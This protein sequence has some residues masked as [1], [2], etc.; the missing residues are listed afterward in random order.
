MDDWLARA[1]QAAEPVSFELPWGTLT[2]LRWGRTD[3]TPHLALHGWL[4][5]AHSFLPLAGAFLQSGAAEKQGLVALEWAGHG[6]SAHRPVGAHYHFIDYVYDLWQLLEQQNW[7]GVPVIAHSMGAFIGNVL[8]GLDTS[9]LSHLYAIEAFGLLTAK[10]DHTAKD[11]LGGFRS[12]LGQEQKRQPVYQDKQKAVAARAAAGDF[13]E[14][15]AALLVDRGIQQGADG[16][17]RFRADG[18]VRV[19]SPYRMVP[20]Q[21]ADILA[22]IECPFQLLRGEQGFSHVEEHLA[23]WQAA[24]PHLIVASIAGGHHVHMEKPNE[25]WQSYQDFINRSN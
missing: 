25:V 22:A 10:P 1:Q 21:I 20:E 12:R 4:D 15:L 3:V 24:V 9:K 8:A 2:G 19:S 13:A 17:W 11:L 16:L 6:H 18:R 7:Q 14:D 5:N 23:H